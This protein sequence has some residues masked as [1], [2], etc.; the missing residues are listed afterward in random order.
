MMIDRQKIIIIA[1]AVFVFLC[2]TL[3]IIS[4]G[5]KETEESV[6]DNYTLDFPLMLP[7]EPGYSGEYM[8]VNTPRDRWS[9]AEVDEW[10]VI[11]TGEN[12]EKINAAN[13]QVIVKVLEAAP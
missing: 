2:I 11:P 7:I 3:I 10:F 13:D 1:S 4:F 12:L 9:E 5:T 8:Y 6:Q